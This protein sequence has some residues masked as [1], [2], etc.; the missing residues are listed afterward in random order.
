M[1]SR[2][3]LDI[4]GSANQV[5]GERHRYAASV[6][7]TASATDDDTADTVTYDLSNDAGGLFKI[8][9]DGVVTIRGSLDYET[10]GSH[11]VL[12]LPKALTA[13]LHQRTSRYKSSMMLM[14][15]R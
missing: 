11:T 2:L 10:A 5:A 12:C 14:M 3:I 1:I 8:N 13:A 9:G 4:D 15:I 6:G 7:I